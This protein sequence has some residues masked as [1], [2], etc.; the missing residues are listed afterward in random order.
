[1]KLIN[2]RIELQLHELRGGEGLALLLLHELGGAAEDWRAVDWS[3]WVGPVY[4]LDFAGHGGSARVVGGGYYAEFFLAD[5]DLAL[6]RLGDRAAVVGAG[7]G[8]YVAL[9]LAGARPDRV[10]AALLR[11][12][13]GLEGGGAEPDFERPIPSF[14]DWESTQSAT[15]RRYRVEVDP[16]VACCEDDLRP[17]DYVADFAR[18]ARRLLF[19]PAVERAEA[20]PPW[21]VRARSCSSGES[22][23]ETFGP[24]LERLLAAAG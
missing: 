15:A 7:I 1:M 24:A 21:W 19:D 23:P 5:A 20:A 6:E 14:Q 4:A 17:P 16:A 3:S 10:P 2:G 13:C 22:A 11:A 8:A 12:G 18:A 9:L